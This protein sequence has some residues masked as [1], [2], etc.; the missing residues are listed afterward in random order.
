MT[1]IQILIVE[2]ELVIARD[3]ERQLIALGHRPVGMATSGEEAVALA[4]TRQPQ[5]VLMDIHLSGPMDGVEAARAIRARTIIPIIFLTAYTTSD[6]IDR[7]KAAEPSGYLI[8]P[9]EP[10]ALRTTIEIAMH[11]HGLAS[12]VWLQ[13]AALNAAANA[14]V[15]TDRDGVVKWVNPAFSQMSGYSAD[16]AIGKNPRDLLRSGVHPREFY[17]GMWLTLLAG[18]VWEGE[19]TNRRK[20]GTQYVEGQTIT[21]VKNS[22]GE[23]T[24]FIA[25][26]RDLTDRRRLQAQ[27]LHAQKMEVVGRLAGGVAHDFNNLLTV[28]NGTADLALMGLPDDHALRSEFAHIKDAGDQAARLTRQ[29]LSF[30]RKQVVNP[31][32]VNVGDNINHMAGLLRRLIGEDIELA[33]VSRPELDSVTIDPG[34]FEQV[35]LNLAVNARDAMPQGGVL[36][37]E[38]S[39]VMVDDV[40]AAGHAPAVAG[41][42]VMVSVTDT[43]VGM[44]AEVRRQMFDPFFT[45]KELGRGTGLGLATVDGI[46]KQAGGC[47]VV[48]SEPGEGASFR[49]YLPTV[50]RGSADVEPAALQ[51]ARGTETILV[52]ED[53]DGLRQVVT[54]MLKGAGFHVLAANGA[55]Q[56]LALLES[57]PDQVHLVFTD[58]VMPGMSGVDLVTAIVAAHPGTKVLFSSGYTDDATM[59]QVALARGRNFIAKPYTVAGLR[60]KIR[61][62]LDA[63]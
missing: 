21:P 28:I 57:H 25:I 50:A 22:A 41:P 18:K 35:L 27:F 24:N 54:R 30:S 36:T 34:Q 5:L 31:A 39:N 14:I 15:I 62:V 7:A 12:Q 61:D 37:V 16:E 46:V 4:A 40:F 56:A 33:V 1:G 48:E 42:H 11:N 47:I 10:I 8:K 45:T 49:I 6:V 13:S 63:G 38:T 29:L 44:T 32:V 19:L 58:V 52:V 2:D 51:P 26:K 23:V 17:Q 53:E 3:I 20:D 59:R 55:K 9:F 60:K 43:G